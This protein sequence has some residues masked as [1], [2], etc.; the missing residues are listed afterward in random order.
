MALLQRIQASRVL[1]R[2]LI[3]ALQLGK[4]INKD[5]TLRKIILEGYIIVPDA[6][7]EIIKNELKT[8][9]NLTREEVGCIKFIVEQDQNDK[10]R[11]NVYEEFLDQNAFNSHQNRVKNS[12]WG[13]VTK[14]VK[15]DYKIFEQD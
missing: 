3:E 14:N 8:H 5:Q 11:F 10:N 4:L 15:R 1:K 13:K 2:R 6:D 9:I 12:Y 7:L